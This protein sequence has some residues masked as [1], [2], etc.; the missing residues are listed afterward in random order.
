MLILEQLI[1]DTMTKKKT[2]KFPIIIGDKTFLNEVGESWE[3]FIDR[4]DLAYVE[5]TLAIKNNWKELTNES[6]STKG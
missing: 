6:I 3:E 5:Y 4:L 1:K 2:I